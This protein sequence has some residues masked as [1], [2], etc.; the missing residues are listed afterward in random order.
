MRTVAAEKE[1]ETYL[2]LERRLC[3]AGAFCGPRQSARQED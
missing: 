1:R 2:R 3:T